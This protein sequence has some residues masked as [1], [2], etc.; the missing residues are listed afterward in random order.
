MGVEQA[1]PALPALAAQCQYRAWSGGDKFEVERKE[2]IAELRVAVLE[3]AL[4]R[5]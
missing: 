2:R 4:R 3:L 1:S 5:K